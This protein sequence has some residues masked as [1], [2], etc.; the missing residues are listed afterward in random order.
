MD[1]RKLLEKQ[2]KR[3][4]S[5][6][7]MQ[8]PEVLQFLEDISR[9]Y[10]AFEK[11][12]Q[13]LTRAYKITEEEYIEINNNLNNEIKN[14][15][16]TI[17]Q[18]KHVL[19]SINSS[20][21]NG[22]NE[23]LFDF[24]NAIVEEIRKRQRI[25]DTLK[26]LIN[27]LNL[28]IIL[29]DATD[30]VIYVNSVVYD[31]FQLHPART[32]DPGE[33]VFQ[34]IK[35]I[36]SKSIKKDV[37]NIASGSSKDAS[38]VTTQVWIMDDGRIIE[39]SV[40]PY[41]YGNNLR[42]CIYTYS[43]VTERERSIE[44]IR[45]SELRNNQILKG[46]PSS[47]I[48]IN[49][50]GEIRFTNQKTTDI[51]GR[52]P[53][54]ILRMK[55]SDLIDLS[56]ILP[57][58]FAQI[59]EPGMEDKLLNRNLELRTKSRDGREQWIE[60][61]IIRMEEI[62][63]ASYCCFSKDI[64]DRKEAEREINKQKKFT[65]DILD[66]I[67]NDIAVFDAHQNY[68]FINRKAVNDVEMRSWLMG[69]NDFD[70]CRYKQTDDSLAVSRQEVFRRSIE[71]RADVEWLDQ[72]QT[73]DGK[74]EYFQRKF[75]PHFEN[76]EIKFV[77]GYGVD[78]TANINN[79]HELEN[80]LQYAKKINN[81][82]EHFAYV[83]SHDL[84]EPLRTITNFL[85]LIE[86]KTQK[87]LDDQTKVYLNFT[88]EAAKRMRLLILDLLEY[89]RVGKATDES[90][91]EIQLNDLIK[92]IILL[93]DRQ[94][95]E[96]SARITVGELPVIKT[97]RTLIRQ[98]F[99]NFINNGLKY[100]REGIPPVINISHRDLQTHWEFSISD[101]GIGIE[102]EYF[103]KIFVIFQR[104]NN[105]DKYSGTGIGLAITKKIIEDMNGKVWLESK[106]NIGTTF[107]FTIMKPQ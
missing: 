25:E 51:F 84:Q 66:N 20:G 77:I 41:L 40:I 16:E 13:L 21:G 36:R 43:D 8:Q 9:S 29:K 67:P 82:L 60:F 86:Q 72:H 54:E 38:L 17:Q 76:D 23:S 73:A 26:S 1:Y 107:H 24:S 44:L 50:Q 18:L 99:Q 68:L 87:S 19:S 53:E 47:V 98:V 96:L 42:G 49:I 22:N 14:R 10:S 57:E 88:I 81:E 3:H 103:D 91:E 33:D 105:R 62:H 70:Y 34:R 46:S 93:H 104:L 92:E 35:E 30:E 83:A 101:N 97:Q 71:T 78:V 15:K 94:I 52:S 102:E 106:K 69:K 7:L 64:T 45:R 28:G 61:S 5:D 85:S 79:Q 56:D 4:L 90:K 59:S 6:A 11:E 89:S 58:G 75:H 65:E 2:V 39:E 48:L 31:L 95:N 80:S 63:E 32:D 100:H 55:V 12:K 37:F 74:T 27:N